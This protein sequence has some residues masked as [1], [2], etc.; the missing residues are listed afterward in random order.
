MTNGI[1]HLGLTVSDVRQAADFFVQV[2][3]FRL[4]A[5]KP[6]Y[7]AAFV[8]DGTIMLT[9]WQVQGDVRPAAFDRKNVLG[10]HHFALTLAAGETLEDAHQRLSVAAGVTIEFVPEQLGP[11]PARHMMCQIPGG[12]RMELVAPE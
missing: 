6:D 2:M 8:S 4:V 3:G 7:P 1:H 10:L 11:G 5:E 9:L 12:L